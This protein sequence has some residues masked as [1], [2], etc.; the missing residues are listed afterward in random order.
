MC[1]NHVV[2][3]ADQRSLMMIF[4]DV[5]VSAFAALML[6]APAGAYAQLASASAN[7]LP[8]SKGFLVT[9]DYVVGGVDLTPQANPADVNGVATGTISISDVPA[10]A[11]IVGAYLYWEE[12]F[13]ATPGVNPAARAKFRGAPISQTALKVSSFQLSSNPATCWGAAGTSGAFVAEYRADVLYLL[14]KRFDSDNKWTGKYLVNGQHTVSLPEQSGNK[15]VASAGATLVIVFRDLSQPLRKVLLFDGAYAQPDG[16]TMVQNLRGFYRSDAVKSA[17]VT[18]I[19]GTGGNNQTE[20]V[21]FNGTIV[22]TTDPFPQTSPS[23]DRSWANPTYVVS[24]LMPGVDYNDGFGETATTTI[25]ASSKPLACRASAAVIFS[26]AIADVDHDGLPDGLE[27]AAGGLNDPPTAS[28]PSGDPLPNLK[29]MGASSSHKDIFIEVNAMKADPGTSYGSASAPF[30]STATTITDAVGHNHLPTPDVLKLVADA[31]A[32]RGVTPHFDVGDI[33]AYHNLGPQY[34]CDP[35]LHP[36]CNVDPYLVPSLYAR[37]G[38]SIK[39]QACAAGDP[40]KTVKCEFASFPGTV[41]WKLGLQLYRDAPVGD[42][43]QELAVAQIANTWQSGEHRR[44]FDRIRQ[45]YFHYIL[46]AHGRG[47]PKSTFPC[48]D[49]SNP[50]NPTGYASDGTCS[51]GLTDNPAFHVP[52]SVSGVADLPGNSVLITLGLW[53][54]FVGTPYVQASTTLHE[55]GHNLNLWH[56]GAPPIWGDQSNPTILE[57]NC[58]VNYL[59]SMNYLFQVHGLFDSSGRLHLDYSG[60]TQSDVDEQHLLDAA[61]GPSAPAYVPAWFTPWFAPDGVSV[62]VL[63]KSLGVSPA[64]RFCNGAR[65]SADPTLAPM[66]MARVFAPSTTAPIDWNGDGLVDFAG[67]QNANYDGT[68]T[69]LGIINSPFKGYND[70]AHIRLDQIAAGRNETKFSDGDFTNLGSG[71]FLDFGSGDFLDFGSGDF[72][73]LG[74]GDFLD[75]GSGDFLDFGSG[76]FLDFGSGDFIDLGSGDFLDFGSGDFLDFGSGDFLDFG[77]GDFLDFGS[78]SQSQELDY[79]TARRLGRAAPFG[80]TGCIIGTTGC[81]QVKTSD[82]TYKHVQLNWNAPP[83]GRVAR[84]QIWR[85]KGDPS[86]TAS[87]KQIGTST[88]TLFVDPDSLATGQPYTYYVRAEISDEMSNSIT[89]LSNLFT[90]TK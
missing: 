11:D 30:N 42:D 29:A 64:T 70:W 58:K 3:S 23:S 68:A 47:K 66:L 59:S 81:T 41:G 65:F 82:P 7:A 12:I 6:L 17:K 31:Y 60:A 49:A 16:A 63:P 44:R 34:A 9:G 83:F 27:D 26:T 89:G 90:I 85:K 84:Y 20:T 77:S 5:R 69:G 55:L 72:I 88:T 73:D 10:D 61:L 75:F 86:S 4:R 13:S 54:N 1:A 22:S 45:D 40:S 71:D 80:L 35:V 50:P 62:N 56:G 52:I 37:G 14:P 32:S 74:S 57:P 51:G 24:S 8:Y 33:T 67:P 53:D 21:S 25:Q 39:E 76:D 28:L 15:A 36:E 87:Y 46:Y 78:G 48:L 79:N 18:H 38:E 19:V 2:Q 43:G